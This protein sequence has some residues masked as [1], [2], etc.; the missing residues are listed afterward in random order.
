MTPER[1]SYTLNVNGAEHEV[2]DAWYFE[3]LLNVLRDHLEL[4]GTKYACDGGQ[5]GACTVHVDGVAVNACIELAAHVIDSKIVTIEGVSG[6]GRAAC[7]QQ[8]LLRGGDVQCGYCM[9][10]VVM[11]ATSYLS[12]QP[13]P[14][15]E[16]I[17]EALSG[18][19]CRC[20]GYSKI[21]E[22]V[23]AASTEDV[24]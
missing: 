22:A 16:D 14:C 20:T 11:A 9:P 8:A 19:L 4:R 23:E 5:C 24:R 1:I 13:K 2:T 10:G 17:R 3:S 18:N 6:Q 12:E 15:A 7:V 21:V